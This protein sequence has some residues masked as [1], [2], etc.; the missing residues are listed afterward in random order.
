MI[1]DSK[2]Y[3]TDNF[4]KLVSLNDNNET[5]LTCERWSGVID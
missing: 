3:F 2:R 5:F 1:I 4:Y